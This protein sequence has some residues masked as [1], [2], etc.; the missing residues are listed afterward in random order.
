M[1][2]GSR[3]F[4]FVAAGLFLAVTFYSRAQ[5][6][7]TN[8][9]Q[10]VSPAEA[11]QGAGDLLVAFTLATG[12]TPPPPGAGVMPTAVT[13]GTNR[14]SSITH[15]GQYV[16]TARFNI[17]P[18]EAVGWKDAA[19][20]FPRPSGGPL[21]FA[22]ASAFEVRAGAPVLAA[23]FSAAPT[24]GAAPLLVV[25]TDGSSG[26][27]TNRRWEFGDGSF[28]SESNPVHAYPGPG[29]YTVALVVFGPGGTN[30]LTRPACIH[31]TAALTNVGAFPVVDTAQSNNYNHSVV[32]G[33]PAGGQPWSGQDAQ[34]AGNAP[35]YRDNGDGTVTDLV[36]G[37]MWQ[38]DPGAKVTFAAATAGA[39]LLTLGGHADWRLPTIKELYS[40]ILFNGSDASS[41]MAPGAGSC[42][43]KPFLDTNYFR[44]QYGDTNAGERIIDAQYWSATE[45]VST[46]MGGNA[47][48]FGVNFADGRIKGYPRDTGPGGAFTEFCRYV[49]GNPNYGVN[50]LL[51]HGDGR[52]T[53]RATG[54]MWTRD[55]SGT[56]LNWSNA[57]AWAQARNAVNHLGHND[58]RLPDAKELQSLVDY[59][60][61]PATTRSAAVSPLFNCTAIID[62]G[63]RTNW[64]FYWAGTT[65]ADS[66]GNGSFAVYVCFGEA[67]GWMT[68]AAAGGYELQDVHGAGAQRS[69]P[70]SGS[71]TNYPHGHGPQ[72]DVVRVTNF[73]RLVRIATTFFDTVG[74][75]VPNSWREARFGTGV[76]TNAITCAGCDP[77]HDGSNNG[78]EF[79]AGTDPGDA[80]SV[81]RA[82]R[83]MGV[84]N[85]VSFQSAAGRLYTLFRC[86]NLHAAA[87]QPVAGQTDVAGTGGVMTLFDPAPPT[88]QCFYRLGVRP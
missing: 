39:G 49:R 48:V 12:T 28:S 7:I 82:T 47:T 69:D 63:G 15:T 20:T 37:L 34:Q 10:S 72:G 33:P 3:I 88:G 55:D 30:L 8:G 45:Y 84:G 74:D 83:S 26:T 56:G 76:E 86:E 29:D 13:L 60:R 65:H 78:S 22:R 11:V 62:E 2:S 75:G 71:A 32:I 64:P 6:T 4:P 58:W 54:L 23:G 68:N 70:K 80:L 50:L 73:V 52:V 53:D 51:D 59:T 41:C 35:R 18:G 67:L 77:D 31:V 61:S 57:L 38:Q 43:A 42:A 16:V 85:G 9:V 19:V 66:T 40:L 27:I 81:F 5:T 79:I 1:K 44:F 25:F 46:T 24:N 87:W 36:T 21:T 14:G 17:A